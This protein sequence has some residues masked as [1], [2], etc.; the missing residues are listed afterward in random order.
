MTGANQS[1][2]IVARLKRVLDEMRTQQLEVMAHYAPDGL[3]F[4]EEVAQIDEFLGAAHELGAAY[5]SI[6]ANLEAA[7]FKLTSAATL[8]LLETGLLMRYKTDRVEDIPYDH[9]D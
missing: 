3:S 5:E 2:M 8:A 9:R 6:V 1:F 7:P 4:A